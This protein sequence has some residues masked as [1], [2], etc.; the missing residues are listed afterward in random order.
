MN[1]F[2]KKNILIG[3]VS[4][5]LLSVCIGL[6]VTY[7]LRNHTI[8][9]GKNEII[10]TINRENLHAKY[11]NLKVEEYNDETL[12]SSYEIKYVANNYYYNYFDGK[13][14]KTIEYKDGKFES[15]FLTENYE[16]YISEELSTK[17]D[18]LFIKDLFT[19]DMVFW[20]ELVVEDSKIT[21]LYEDETEGKSYNYMFNFDGLLTSKTSID[22]K[23]KL[24]VS[25]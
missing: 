25:F 23:Y 11:K 15:N 17:L 13:T 7:A 21:Y 22:N 4:L 24:Q 14:N 1:I 3:S 2:T 20:E 8:E 9:K 10:S 16:T 6:T 12:S 5:C 19:Y 18:S